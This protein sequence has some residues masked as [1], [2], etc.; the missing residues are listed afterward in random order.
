M[1][2]IEHMLDSPLKLKEF[3]RQL[4]AYEATAKPAGAKDAGAFCVCEK[5]RVPLGRLIGIIGFRSLLAR[6]LALAGDDMPLLRALHIKADGTLEGIN[7]LQAK[8]DEGEIGRGEVAL[9]AQ[10]IGLLVTF[11]GEGLM[12]GLVQGVWPKV[13]PPPAAADDSNLMKESTREQTK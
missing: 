5:L 12:L 7:E 8:L 13:S 3:A 2:G 6:A 4:L 11:I 1:F 10:L 9:V